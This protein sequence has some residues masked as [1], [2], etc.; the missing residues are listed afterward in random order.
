[1]GRQGEKPQLRDP[2]RGDLAFTGREESALA[3][4]VTGFLYLGGAVGAF[5]MLLLPGPDIENPGILVATAIG[6]LI[7][8]IAC[9]TVLDFTRLP[10]AVTYTSTA[11]GLVII[12][13]IWLGSRGT[14][15]PALAW[16][17]FIVAFSAIFYSWRVTSMFVVATCVVGGVLLGAYPDALGT[18]QAVRH[19]GVGSIIAVTVGS[20]IAAGR[21]LLTTMRRQ[22]EALSVAHMQLAQE[23]SALRRVATAVAAGSPPSAVLALVASEVARLVDGD[24]ASVTRN[25]SEDEAIVVGAW[26]RDGL[27]RYD[28]GTVLRRDD[29]AVP[30]GYGYVVNAPIH[31]GA[32]VWGELSVMTSARGGVSSEAEDR[33]RDFAGLAATAIANAEDRARLTAMAANDALTG[34]PNRRVFKDRLQA[35]VSRAS[36]HGRAVAIALIDI[37]RFAEANDR[38]GDAIGDQI[39]REAATLLRSSLRGAD[40]VARLGGD[41]FALLLPETDRHRAYGVCER[42]RSLVADTAFADRTRLTV[43]AGVCDLDTAGD[44]DAM[45]RLAEGALYWSK[46]H[47]R[48]V[49]WIYDPEVV[50][51]LNAAERAEHLERTQALAGLRALARA[52]DARDG[53][54]T[55]HSERVAVLAGRLA[56]ARGWSGRRAAQLAEAALVHDIGKI[57]V[58]EALLVKSEPL[59]EEEYETVKGHV[60]LGAQIVADVLDPEQVRWIETHHERPDGAG[61]PAGLTGEEIPEGGALLALADAWDVMTCARPYSLERSED[62]AFSEIESLVGRQF[63]R[64]AV[65]A[66]RELR[67]H[68]LRD[69]A[70]SALLDADE[71]QLDEQGEA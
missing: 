64:D 47:G 52:V 17:W 18:D 34:L 45:F 44:P 1:M 39:L 68:G 2:D 20:I 19:A 28:T 59:S 65:D 4:R 6:G 66:L 37:D 29:T 48:D 58:P 67:A 53:M 70:D 41:E 14:A 9:L 21:A 60:T 51:E 61:Y 32:G 23:Q 63:T 43:S 57:G 24:A 12:A 25:I 31:A 30:L 69:D 49:T 8:A 13:V 50:G 38:C 16:V 46:A 27:P 42:I 54:K 10:A 3:Q 15:A 22:S 11:A 7:W 71:I 5:A 36:R 55:E 40:L 56:V 62:H 33:L 35:E 26:S